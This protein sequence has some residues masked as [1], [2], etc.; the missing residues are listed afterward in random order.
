MEESEGAGSDDVDCIRDYVCYLCPRVA[1]G[2]L[3]SAYAAMRRTQS[4]EHQFQASWQNISG[5]SRENNS[6][7]VDDTPSRNEYAQRRLARMDP[8]LALPRGA[9]TT[10]HPTDVGKA[11]AMVANSSSM[12]QNAPGRRLA[13]MTLIGFMPGVHNQGGIQIECDFWLRGNNA[14]RIG[15]NK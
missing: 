15:G 9:L 12:L 3:L 13:R 8:R 6:C 7:L 1:S 11:R 2:R 5:F 4:R 10:V 14:E